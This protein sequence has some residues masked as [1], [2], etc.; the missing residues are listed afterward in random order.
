MF[1]AIYKRM[2]TENKRNGS[3]A[4]NPEMFREIHTETE[5]TLGLTVNGPISGAKSKSS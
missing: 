4:E 2:G 5:E 1:P 3:L